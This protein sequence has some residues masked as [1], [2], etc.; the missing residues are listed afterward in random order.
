MKEWLEASK[1]A[2]DKSGSGIGR[3]QLLKTVGLASV[4]LAAGSLLE[5]GKA[6]ASVTGVYLDV[7]DFGAAGNGV[8]DDWAAFQAA[9]DV[10]KNPNDVQNSNKSV[11]IV[12][13]EG[14]YVVRQELRLYRNTTLLMAPKA[15]IVRMHNGYILK[16]GFKNSSDP[17]GAPETYG[18]YDGHGN[19]KIVGGTFDINADEYPSK[20]SGFHFGHGDGFFIDGITMLDAANS[21][22]IEFNACQNVVVTRSK[23][24]GYIGE[25]SI[26]EAIQLDLAYRGLTTIG[27]D[28]G[29][30]CRNVHITQCEFKGSSTPGAVSWYRAVGSHTAMAGKWHED[31]WVTNNTIE[32][33][34]SFAIR[35][36]SW[37]RFHIDNNHL[38]NCAAGINVR[39]SIVGTHTI[40]VNGNQTNTSQPSESGTV[41]GNLIVGGLTNGRAIEVYGGDNGRPTGIMVIGN[42]ITANSA[43]SINDGINIHYGDNCIVS[44]NRIS[45]VGGSGIAVNADSLDTVVDGNSIED[46][47][48][49]GILVDGGCHYTKVTGNNIKLVDQIGIYVNGSMES[50]TVT[51]NTIA[52]VNRSGADNE[53]IK[54]NGSVKRVVLSANS[55]RNFST[56]AVTT[57]GLTVSSS[58]DIFVSVGNNFLGFTVSNAAT[59]QKVFDLV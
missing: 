49:H 42:D 26:N 23:F 35:A 7:K 51:G 55:V 3:R 59:N 53:F 48:R 41:S 1:N 54:F 31:I 11:T 52:G 36:Y 20:A 8:A 30:A 34:G 50:I 16:N 12:V 29:T 15:R 32:N 40:D 13:P 57:K 24:H 43:T 17:Q 22:G 4:A 56:N 27:R 2:E 5:G 37:R 47:K 6:S 25:G 10:A 33:S 44:N 18:G 46:A 14:T 28:D 45:G 9:F 19:I 39:T 38:I 21:H 58:S